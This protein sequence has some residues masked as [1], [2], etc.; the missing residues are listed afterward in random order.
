MRRIPMRKSFAVAIGMLAVV[1][2]ATAEDV[3]ESRMMSMELARDMASRAVETCRAQ[4]FQVSVV[5]VDRAG[6]VQTLLRD[7]LAT[8]F[9]TELALKKANAVILS[10]T[11]GTEFLANRPDF[12]DKANLMDDVLALQGGVPIRAAGSLLGAIGVSGAR[13]GDIDEQCANA[14][15]EAV[16]DR[17]EF[18]D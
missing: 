12:T 16:V 1:N 7:P 8:R 15:L 17:L 14:A 5:V 11:S 10:G 4:G 13:G 3:L 9:N 2:A 6:V 18:V